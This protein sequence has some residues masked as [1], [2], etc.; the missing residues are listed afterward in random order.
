MVVD[1]QKKARLVEQKRKFFLIRRIVVPSPALDF[2][3]R[4]TQI[5][6]HITL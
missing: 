1:V 3:S 2:S 4:Y 6:F 5:Y